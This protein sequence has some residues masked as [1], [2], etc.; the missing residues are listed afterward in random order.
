M[1][2]AG[3][4]TEVPPHTLHTFHRNA[5]RGDVDVIAGSLRAHGQYRPVVANIGTYTGRPFEVLAGNHTLMAVRKLAETY[6]DDARWSSI[7]V[8]WGDWDETTCTKI[9][10]ADNRTAEVGTMDFQQL[11]ELLDSLPDID[12]TGYTDIDY[13]ALSQAVAGPSLDDLADEF[14]HSVTPD[15]LLERVQLKLSGTVNQQWLAHRRKYD[16]DDGAMAA[17]LVSR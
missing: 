5:R 8:H 3:T 9:V 13:T 7:K 6:P 12:A 4:T 16:S 1:H 14:G 15:D 17:L 2:L 10:L 11:K